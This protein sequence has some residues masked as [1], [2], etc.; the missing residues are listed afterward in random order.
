MIEEIGPITG[1][2]AA[3]KLVLHQG[4]ALRDLLAVPVDV[5][6]PVELDV[7]DGQADA[8]DRAHPGDARQPV[9]PG[10]DGVG[11]ELLDL[12]RGVALRLGHDGDG[13]AG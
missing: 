11:D 9:H 6:A 13:R 3:R 1:R 2:H 8:R 7:G 10:L 5:G 4:E 12:L